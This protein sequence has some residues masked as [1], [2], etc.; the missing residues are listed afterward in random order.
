MSKNLQ[1][2][3]ANRPTGEVTEANF[4]IVER[5]IPTAGPGQILVRNHWLSL[6][7]YMRGRMAASKSYAAS[8]EIGEVM[9]G[10]TT[11]RV[12]RPRETL[13]DLVRGEVV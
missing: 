10:G 6:D 2:L 1:V 7:P 8:V 9:V 3:L 13:D 11:W 12:V 4:E 5:D